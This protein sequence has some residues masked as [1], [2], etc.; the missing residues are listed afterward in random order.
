MY[1][2]FDIAYAA[3]YFFDMVRN[4][5]AQKPRYSMVLLHIP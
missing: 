2:L 3:I 5:F 1:D 4:G